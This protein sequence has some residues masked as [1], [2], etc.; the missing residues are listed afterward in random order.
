MSSKTANVQLK[1][2]CVDE[3]DPPRDRAPLAGEQGAVKGVG[4]RLHDG[5]FT[6]FQCE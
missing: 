1:N 2:L 5:F 3:S 4:E 6:K